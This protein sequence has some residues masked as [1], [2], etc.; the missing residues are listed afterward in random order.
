MNTL[1]HIFEWRKCGMQM[2]HTESI[3]VSKF[4]FFQNFITF[5]TWIFIN[6]R[7]A[8]YIVSIYISTVKY[9]LSQLVP[10]L[11]LKWLVDLSLFLLSTFKSSGTLY[12]FS[13]MHTC[14]CNGIYCIYTQNSTVFSTRYTDTSNFIF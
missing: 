10:K 13:L 8:I 14:I 2:S 11:S 1:I 4:Y 3:V 9:N 5:L 6:F 7:Y 12:P